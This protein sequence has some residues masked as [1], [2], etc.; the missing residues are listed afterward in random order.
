VANGTVAIHLALVALGVGPGDEVIVPTFTYIAS[1]NTILQTGAIPVYV[2]SC[3]DTL[4]M[5][6]AAVRAAISERTKAVMA[7][8]L[9]GHPCDMG[10]LT[11]LCDAHGLLLIVVCADAFGSFWVGHQVGTFG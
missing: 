4:Q 11:S 3:D 7:V 1:V 8:H 6:P 9:Y 5:D 2:D 10:A